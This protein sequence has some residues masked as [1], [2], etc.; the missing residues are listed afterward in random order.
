MQIEER[1]KLTYQQPQGDRVQS[2]KE[3][4]VYQQF[5]IPDCNP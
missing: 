3:I 2:Q 4:N 1:I 5:K